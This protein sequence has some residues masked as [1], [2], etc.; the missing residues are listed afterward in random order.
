[1]ILLIGGEKGGAGKSTIA[2]NLAAFLAHKKKDILL[3]DS[4]PQKSSSTWSTRRNKINDIPKVHCVEKTGNIS[5]SIN[6]FKQRYEYIIID[7][8]GRDSKELRSGLITAEVFY[9][10]IKPSQIDIDTLGKMNELV[11]QALSMNIRL[12]S[13]SIITHAPTNPNM[14]DEKETQD[15]LNEIPNFI[16]SKV[17]IKYRSSYWRAM[18]Q[19]ISVLE[20]FDQKAKNEIIEL[21]KEIFNL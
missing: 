3:V 11:E 8:G 18:G 15:I 19:G 13:Y 2:C 5:E 6:D 7:T 12:K 16:P 17:I 9:T 1:M 4:D 10:P 14:D 20:Y 21:G